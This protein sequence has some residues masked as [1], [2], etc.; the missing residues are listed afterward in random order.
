[1]AVGM[2]MRERMTALARSVKTYAADKPNVVAE[3]DACLAFLDAADEQVKATIAAA[4]A[5]E[6][7]EA[8][9][10]SVEP[11]PT[12]PASAGTPKTAVWPDATASTG[13]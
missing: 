6:A 3:A 12:P 11:E 8:E 7:A 13:L 2:Q 4:Q 9:P 1:M 10:E 5:A